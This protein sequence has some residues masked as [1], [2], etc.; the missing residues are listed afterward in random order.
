MRLTLKVQ[1]IVTVGRKLAIAG[2]FSAVVVVLLLWLA[3]RFSPKIASSRSPAEP[4]TRPIPAGAAVKA[5]LV[6]M[7]R[8]ES[9]VGS[10][11]A[12]QET[13][14]ASRIIARVIEINLKAGQAVRRGEVL[15]RLDDTDLRA[16]LQQAE[17][18]VVSAQAQRDQAAIDER[19]MAPLV[20]GGA[21]SKGD[22]ERAATTLKSAEADLARARQAVTE[23]QA[24]LEYATIRSPMDGI[25]VDKQVD[26]GH[27]A[28]PGLPLLKIYDPTRM[29][30]IADV[31]ESLARRLA[32]GQ[33]I[34][35]RLDV[36]EKTCAGQVSEIVP[37]SQS[38]SRTFQVKVTGPC[39]P[40]LYTGMFGRV[41]VP[42][43]DEEV[44]VIPGSAVTRVGQL[45]LVDVVEEGASHR[46]AVRTGRVLG[47][48]REILSGLRVDEEVLVRGIA[49]TGP[50]AAPQIAGGEGGRP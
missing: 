48:D 15:V 35:V 30:L 21:V 28:T 29:Q 33:S 44:L 25:V 38:E 9:A 49:A 40:G 50:T 22:Y 32:V 11:Q 46:R 7:P 37:D 10:V 47:D 18:S 41:L 45:E 8:V 1:K 24:V 12:V 26:L 13:T 5:R 19:R 14:I 20:E 34:G 4:S 31:R 6:R 43:D 39:P 17:A 42:L 27:T 2:V 36:L 3:G 23:A 16:R